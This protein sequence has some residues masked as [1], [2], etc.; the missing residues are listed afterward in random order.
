ME[1]VIVWFRNDLRLHDNEMLFNALQKTP[2]IIP[3]YCFDTRQFAMTDLGFR[4][5]NAFRAKFLIEAVADLRQNLQK[6]GSNLIIKIGEPENIVAELQQN[7]GAKAVYASKEVTSEETQV[8]QRLESK[9]FKVGCN[10]NLYWQSTLY[11]FDDLPFPI[12]N[13]PDIYTDFRKEVEKSVKVRPQFPILKKV[14]ATDIEPT[15]LPTI[16][17]LGLEE[18]EYDS[19]SV[20]NFKGGETAGRERLQA[21]FWKQNLLK[22]YKE[23]RN[24]L[25]GADYSSKFSAWL[26]LGCLSP[27]YI[28]EEVKKYEQNKIKNDSTYWLIF[29]LIWRDYFRFVAK[30]YKDSIFD[31]AGIRKQNLPLKNDKRLFEKW[32]EGKTGQPFVDANMIEL[33]KTGFMSNRGRQNVA[34]YLIKDMK[35]NWQWGA[36]WFESQ[37]I[38]YDVCSNWGNWNYVAGIGNDP[39]ENRYFNVP[40]QAQRYDPKGEYVKLWLSD[41]NEVVSLF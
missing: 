28:F 38:D 10:L 31:Y 32:K 1:K 2:H 30:K 15:K 14:E 17:E 22:T 20:L 4:K 19:R 27:R 8:E 6:I 33:K 35:V 7:I 16:C 5:T 29:E 12:K 3:I 36:A 26:A 40:S 21:Y 41:K 24:G 37:L 13:L 39:R 11:H 18:A 9:L 34:S 25:I 23:T